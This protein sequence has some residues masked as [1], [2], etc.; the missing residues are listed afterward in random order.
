MPHAIALYDCEGD[1]DNELDFEEG[2]RIKIISQEWHGDSAWWYGELDGEEGCFP[3]NYVE[4]DRSSAQAPPPLAPRR[5]KQSAIGASMFRTSLTGAIAP[6]NPSG[7]S[8]SSS[9]KK[10]K[11]KKKTDAVVYSSRGTA[12]DGK[13]WADTSSA[14]ASGAYGLDA[15]LERK[16]AAN[17][18]RGAES[19]A[20]VWIE[21]LSGKRY[22][23]DFA[24]CV[25]IFHYRV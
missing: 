24:T 9:S 8:S 3:S 17:Y 6:I 21:S 23:G 5:R 22:T 20:A 1:E 25:F 19:R 16:K 2:D 13:D 7:G 10:K 15:A 12:R 14:S 4:L 18:D 11:K